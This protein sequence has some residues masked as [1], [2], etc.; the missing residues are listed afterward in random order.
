LAWSMLRN[1]HRRDIALI[2][3]PGFALGALRII[4]ASAV[5]LVV[6]LLR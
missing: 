6:T 2:A 4:I 3:V 5:H 1:E